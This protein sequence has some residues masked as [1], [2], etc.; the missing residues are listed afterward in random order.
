MAKTLFLLIVEHVRQ[1]PIRS[2][3]TVIGVA[4]GVAAWLAIRLANVEVFRV[5]QESVDTVVG[6][7][8]I[9]ISGGKGGFDE[10]VI[11]QV[12]NHP[13]VVA[14]SPLLQV[15]GIVLN[16]GQDR[17]P[18]II[19]GLDFI[20]YVNEGEV[21]FSGPEREEIG[22]EEFLDVK[23]VFLGKKLAQDWDLQVGDRKSVV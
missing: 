3:L 2:T 18:M 10:R 22:M 15:S 7:T 14:A 13:D 19:W 12:R 9:Q 11:S 6:H 23:S 4:I 5:F 20:E 16:E 8:T 1:R 21:E 17:K